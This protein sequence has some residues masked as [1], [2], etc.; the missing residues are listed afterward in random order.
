[1]APRHPEDQKEFVSWLNRKLRDT[2]RADGQPLRQ[3]DL[4][5]ALGVGAPFV[6]QILN[7]KRIAGAELV[8]RIANFFEEDAN[9]LLNSA[10]YETISDQSDVDKDDPDVLRVFAAIKVLLRDRGKL[11]SAVSMLEGLAK[12]V[13]N[14]RK[15]DHGDDRAVRQRPS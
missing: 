4:A 15:S 14:S 10:H 7:G 6:S 8:I 5:D 13:R 11:Q 9:K 12:D 3:S 2:N 1:M